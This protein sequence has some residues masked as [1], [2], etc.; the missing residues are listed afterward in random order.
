MTRDHRPLR[1]LIIDDHPLVRAGL[2]A[3]LRQSLPEACFRD[4]ATA[5]EAL[6]AFTD[7][8]P[9][10]VLLDVNLSG[11]NGLDLLKCFRDLRMP[12]RILMVAAEA[13]PWTV[14]EA[15]AGGAS[16]FVSKTNSA[17]CLVRAVEAVLEGKLFLCTDSQLA[18]RRAEL[19][20]D[21]PF[22]S[23]PPAVLSAREREVLRYLAHG[24]NTK[25]IAAILGISAKTVETHRSH[26][27]RKLGV[28][29]TAGLVRYAIRHGLT[30]P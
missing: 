9:H 5:V 16:G 14:R 19:L 25:S 28:Y 13:D 20:G 18:A 8:P 1:I 26:V 3:A 10:L 7:H 17:D 12:A 24:E 21:K 30:T 27:M 2:R 22:D 4:V 23:P 6:K 11:G 15:L 29:S